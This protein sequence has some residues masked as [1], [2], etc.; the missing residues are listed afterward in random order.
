LQIAFIVLKLC[1]VI[2]WSWWLVLLPTLI[3]AGIALLFLL[4]IAVLVLLKVRNDAKIERLKKEAK[5]KKY[6]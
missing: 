5:K 2:N 6:F 4:A 3:S 1:A